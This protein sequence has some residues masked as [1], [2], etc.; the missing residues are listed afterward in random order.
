[1]RRIEDQELKQKMR[2]ITAD[3]SGDPIGNASEN[4]KD[5][6]LFFSPKITT[7]VNFNID[8]AQ[9]V[10]I[11]IKG[12]SID[13]SESFQQ[14]TR[15]RKIRN[16]YYFALIFSKTELPTCRRDPSTDFVRFTLFYFW[17][18]DLLMSLDCM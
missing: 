9:D 18:S 5:T 11:Y 8:E 16:I 12:R 15:T 6:Y 7:G 14:A 13:V 1:M 4:L 17:A 10:L 3:E 2:I